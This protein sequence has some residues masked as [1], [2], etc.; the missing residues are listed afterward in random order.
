MSIDV[1]LVKI[2]IIVFPGIIA[3]GLFNT[4][5]ASRSNSLW[6]ASLEIF[7]FSFLSYYLLATIQNLLTWGFN[8]NLGSIIPNNINAI[9]EKATLSWMDLLLASLLALLI[10]ILSAFAYNNKIV[11]KFGQLIHVTKKYGDEDVWEYMLN[12]PNIEWIY[13]RD[14]ENELTYYGYAKTFSDSNQKREILLTDVDVFNSC[15]G[16]KIDSLPAVY[17]PLSEKY[18]IEI[19]ELIGSNPEKI[20]DAVFNNWSSKCASPDEVNL[21]KEMYKLKK[22]GKFYLRRYKKMGKN[23]ELQDLLGKISVTKEDKDAEKT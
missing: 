7:V 2:V 13:V 15:D 12:S 3:F 9:I 4:L 6:E 16:A 20:D 18:V 5:R 14:L 11:N 1:T 8:F 10:G 21:L 17:L 19:P 22:D 23:I